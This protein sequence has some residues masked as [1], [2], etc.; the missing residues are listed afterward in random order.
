MS[1]P[2][3]GLVCLTGLFHACPRVPNALTW[4]QQSWQVVLPFSWLIIRADIYRAPTTYHLRLIQELVASESCKAKVWPC[5]LIPCAIVPPA[6]RNF[7]TYVLPSFLTLDLSLLERKPFWDF[8]GGT[9]AKTPCSQ[10][11]GPGFN[12]W[13]GN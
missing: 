9:V 3:C 2:W 4:N 11:R 13:S 8:P 5:S 10:C 7:H 1:R 12:P 6:G